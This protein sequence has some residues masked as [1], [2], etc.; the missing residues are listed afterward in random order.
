MKK[1]LL[2]L[3]AFSFLLNACGGTPAADAPPELTGEDVQATAL[4]MAWT[5][6]A[7][8]MAAMPTSTPIPPTETPTIVPPTATMTLVPTL[9]LPTITN[10]PDKDRCNQPLMSTEGQKTKL[11]IFNQ[12]KYSVNISLYLA[13]NNAQNEC[14]YIP[15]YGA[16]LAKNQ[17]TS[18]EVPYS[19]GY[20]YYVYAWV[21]GDSGF[22]LSGGPFTIN[23][24]DKW[25][26]H[27]RDSFIKFVGP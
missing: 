25:E 1:I 16:P 12:T 15:V 13:P 24:S 19:G 5:M 22:S 9:A 4:A 23:N 18:L 3:A 7:E 6:A 2:T 14:G 11:V 8:T 26:I 10:T 20:T 17:D 27:I 21:S